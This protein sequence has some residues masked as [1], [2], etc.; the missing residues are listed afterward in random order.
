MACHRTTLQ[1]KPPQKLKA[2]HSLI[3]LPLFPNRSTR[4]AIYNNSFFSW[5]HGGVWPWPMHDTG[6]MPSALFRFVLPTAILQWDLY[7]SILRLYQRKLKRSTRFCNA[8]VW[9]NDSKTKFW[10]NVWQICHH[11]GNKGER[12]G[13]LTLTPIGTWHS[14]LVMVLT[15]WPDLVVQHSCEFY[16]KTTVIW[17]SLLPCGVLAGYS[18]IKYPKFELVPELKE[19]ALNELTRSTSV[20]LSTLLRQF[21]LWTRRRVHANFT[22]SRSYRSKAARTRIC[23]SSLLV[24]LFLQHSPLNGSDE[25]MI[26]ATAE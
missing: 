8:V 9:K 10:V 7:T 22:S 24:Y 17:H 2:I 3:G 14:S 18:Y 5:P 26:I 11:R 6:V 1:P 16:V 4:P 13:L 12:Q 20:P 19:T 15:R 25:R 21:F 23:I